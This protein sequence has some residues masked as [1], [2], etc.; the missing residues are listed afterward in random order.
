[1]TNARKARITYLI[2]LRI[3]EAAAQSPARRRYV[4]GCVELW[5]N[6]GCQFKAQRASCTLE[7]MQRRAV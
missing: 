5:R 3:T 1:M 2:S 7:G 6:N 4:C